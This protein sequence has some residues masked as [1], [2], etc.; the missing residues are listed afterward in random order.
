[1]SERKGAVTFK[2][3]PLTLV[4]NEI[5]AGDKAPEVSLWTTD[6][7]EMKISDLKGSLVVLSA[8]PS[9]DTPVCNLETKRFSKE[10]A[11]LGDVRFVTVSRDTPFAINRWANTEC[12]ENLLFLSDF[13]CG[14]FGQAYGI[15]IKELSLLARTVFVIDKTGVVRYVQLVREVADEPDYDAILEQLKKLS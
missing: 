1:M 13:R 4:G 2:G 5:K 10:A 7:Q 15:L 3:N 14:E 11:R 9:L 12:I 6:L 8:V